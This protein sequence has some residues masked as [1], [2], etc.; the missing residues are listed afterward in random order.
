MNTE[1]PVIQW[2]EF[3]A[4]VRN[5]REVVDRPDAPR[6]IYSHA[7]LYN[8]IRCYNFL[9]GY[10]ATNVDDSFLA[11]SSD[12]DP[13]SASMV[14]GDFIKDEDIDTLSVLTMVYAG[15]TTYNEMFVMKDLEDNGVIEKIA[16]LCK[17]F[18]KLVQNKAATTRNWEA[19][20]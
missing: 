12:L 8:F 19:T 11:G 17:F 20:A 7:V 5:F 16:A 18:E 6:K 2:S 3:E 10:T 15:L 1:G 4:V 14:K 13:I 9:L